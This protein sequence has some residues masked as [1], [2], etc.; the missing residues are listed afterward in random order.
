MPSQQEVI[1]EGVC[2][3]KRRPA[4]PKS[5]FWMYIISEHMPGL[6]VKGVAFKYK[7][8]MIGWLCLPAYSA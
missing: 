2:S 8:S 6:K 4:L 5:L 1:S 3:A 7:M